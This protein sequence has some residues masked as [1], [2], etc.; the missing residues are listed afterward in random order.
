MWENGT[1]APPPEQKPKPQKSGED[2]VLWAQLF[3]CGL[4][5]AAV[6][7]VILFGP[8]KKRQD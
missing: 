6:W 1:P 8:W 7:G 3:V 5:L 4:A 2:L